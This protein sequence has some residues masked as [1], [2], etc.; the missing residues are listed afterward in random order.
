M[1]YTIYPSGYAVIVSAKTGYKQ[2]YSGFDTA[3]Q[4]EQWF[5]NSTIAYM[6]HEIV[7]H[8]TVNDDLSDI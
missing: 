5:K 8:H 3:E 4:V 6:A 2:V 7:E 1:I